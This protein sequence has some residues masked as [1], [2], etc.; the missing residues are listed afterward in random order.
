[1]RIRIGW[2]RALKN[3]ALNWRMPSGSSGRWLRVIAEAYPAGANDAIFECDE[4]Q[5]YGV[6]WQS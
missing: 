3:S 6:P 4:E 5:R 1:M 2:A